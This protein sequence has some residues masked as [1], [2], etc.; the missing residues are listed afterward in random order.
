MLLYRRGIAPCVVAPPRDFRK[1]SAGR[2]ALD[3][4]GV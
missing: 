2:A 1:Q 3:G 4:F